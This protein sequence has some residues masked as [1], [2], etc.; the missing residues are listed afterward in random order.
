[1][2]FQSAETLRSLA[3]MSLALAMVLAGPSATVVAQVTVFLP[4]DGDIKAT[5]AL[6]GDVPRGKEAYAECQTCH[7][8]DASGRSSFNIPRLSGQHASVLIK[9]LMDIRSGLRVNEDMREYMH[10]SDL[11]LQDFADM[12]AYLQSLPVVGRIGQGPPE[13]VPRGQALYASDCSACH[14]EHGEGPPGAFLSHARVA[15][16]RLSGARDRPHPERRARQFQP[17]DAADPEGL[18]DRRQAGGR[19]VSGAAAGARKDRYT[20]NSQIGTVS[21]LS[22]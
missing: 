2:K 4:T 12:A 8:T 20:G 6:P 19:S 21:W 1:M 9:Q 10:D 17:C 3:T 15:A 14:G 22:A 5:L 7:R 13:L 11:T 16:L 18:F